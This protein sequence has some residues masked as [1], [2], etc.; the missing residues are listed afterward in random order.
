MMEE[1]KDMQGRDMRIRDMHFRD[2]GRISYRELK[3]QEKD[4]VLP[5]VRKVESI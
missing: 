2:R 3:S 4:D 5:R 1:E